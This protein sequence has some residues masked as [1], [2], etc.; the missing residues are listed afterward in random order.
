MKYKALVT[1]GSKGIGLEIVKLLASK[2]IQVW[3]T[4]NNTTPTT[5]IQNVNF[6]KL[7]VT[8]ESECKLFIDDLRAH[9]N[10]PDFL[11]NNAGIVKDKMFHKMTSDEW[12]NVLQVNLVSLFNLTNPVFAHM[13]SKNFGRIVNISS[14]NANKGQLGQVNYCASKAGV[15]GFTKA[16]AL[17]AARFGITVNSISPGY[18][19]TDMTAGISEDVL[20]SIVKSIPIGRMAN[21]SEIAHAV[22]FLLSDDSAYITGTNIEVNGGLYFS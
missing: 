2:N 13:R 19:L 4:Y 6:V 15:Q 5:S 1:G 18:T 9:G 16:L 3:A 20:S 7:D 22:S 8:S 10:M 17:E 11:I 21:A 14:V 12:N